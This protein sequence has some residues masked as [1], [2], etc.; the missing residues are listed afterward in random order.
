MVGFFSQNLVKYQLDL[1]LASDA[2]ASADRA[3]RIFAQHLKPDSYTFGAGQS[4]RGGA[5]LVA[6]KAEPALKDLEAAFQTSQGVFGPRHAISLRTASLRA[7][8]LGL[9]G[10]AQEATAAVRSLAEDPDV[11]G[12]G[13]PIELPYW[14]GVAARLTG[15]HREALRLQEM[16]VARSSGTAHGQRQ[17]MNALAEV[18]LNQAALGA[19]ADAEHSLHAALMMFKDLHVA[20]SPPWAEA[21]VGMGRAKIS[22]NDSAAALPLLHQADAFWRDFDPNSRGAGEA[23]FWLGRCYAALSRPADAKKAY[24]RAA[25]ILVRSPF[26]GDA[27]LLKIAG[28]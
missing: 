27:E 10:R 17:K 16:V 5:L 2:L 11:M 19:H 20:I 23:A 21:L 8:A 12:T 7:A 24:A 3:M 25:Q 13:K 9:V 14:L 6:R 15:D 18:G 28:R 26:P 22:L 4:A 1:G